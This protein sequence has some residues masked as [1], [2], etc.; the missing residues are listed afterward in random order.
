MLSTGQKGF[1]K[2][3]F[4]FCFVYALS[5]QTTNAMHI[6]E[7][8]LPKGWSIGWMILV[9]PF[10]VLGYLKI[11]VQ[12]KENSDTVLIFAM[13]AAYVFVISALKMPSVTGSSSHATGIAL[14]AILLGPAPMSII[15]L[16]VLLFQAILLSHGGLTTLGAN[17]FSMAIVGA[18]V[19]Y[20]AY[21]L[22]KKMKAPT[23]VAIFVATFLSNMATYA[24]TSLQLGLAHPAAN[25][26]VFEATAKFLSVFL[27][28]QI[29]LATV[30]AILTV[31][32]IE[33]IRNRKI[34]SKESEAL[35]NE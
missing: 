8:F 15:G 2:R 35:L 24:T 13:A 12:S 20:G 33:G 6:M 29:P 4:I 5:T 14:G 30:E 3:L 34:F 32:I 7:G 22:L 28:T 11:K 18:F 23:A 16:I 25:G 17:I 31:L 21:V 1:I 26:G 19:A 27:V 9:I 10:L